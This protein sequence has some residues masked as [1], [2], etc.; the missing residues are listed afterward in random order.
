MYSLVSITYNSRLF[1]KIFVNEMNSVFSVFTLYNCATWLERE[2]GTCLEYFLKASKFMSY[3]N[4]L[5]F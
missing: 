1:V 4:R 2:F 3:F 5:W